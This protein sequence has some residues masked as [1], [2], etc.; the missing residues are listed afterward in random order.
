MPWLPN[1]ENFD[2]FVYTGNASV[3]ITEPIIDED[4]RIIS[5]EITLIS[6]GVTHDLIT[7]SLESNRVIPSLIVPWYARD[8]YGI[9]TLLYTPDVSLLAEVDDN[10]LITWANPTGITYTLTLNYVNRFTVWRMDSLWR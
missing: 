3:N 4:V 2:S 5:L 7:T 9:T 8:L 6:Q 1:I 10:I